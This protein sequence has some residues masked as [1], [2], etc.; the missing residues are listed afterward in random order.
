MGTDG[1][2]LQ[3]LTRALDRLVAADPTCL[4]DGHAVV[5]LSRQLTRLEAV[6]ARAGAAFDRSGRWQADGARTPEAWLAVRCSLPVRTARRRVALGRAL[7][8]LPVAERAWLAGEVGSSAVELLA[9]ARTEATAAALSEHE[10]ELVA[11]A[12]A[13][14]PG[15]FAR[16]V[17]YWRQGA[18]PDGAEDEAAHRHDARHVHL[19]SSFE[20]RWLLDGVLDPIGG[21][22]VAT[23]LAQVDDE[24]FRSDWAE[25]R[26]EH[27]EGATVEALARTPGQRRADALVELARR[28]GA[29]DGRRWPRPLF[30]VHVDHGTLAGRICELARSRTVITP[31][32]LVPWL[33]E[34][35]VERVVFDGGDRVLAVG[36]ARRFFTGADRRAVEVRDRECASPFCDVP[37]EDCEVDHVVPFADGGPTVADNGRLACGFHN[38]SRPG[39]SRPP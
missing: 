20:G 23:A 26:A 1:D 32:T 37:A 14:P 16:V 9:R 5:A 31:G 25:A 38:R 33:T 12:R 27:G 4:A 39:A 3:Q 24:L 22:I 30:S 29:T 18:D 19:S 34:A 13:L 35:A 10:S 7:C 17:A 8:H 11:H 15:A 21:E 6:A 36:P 28:A 2:P